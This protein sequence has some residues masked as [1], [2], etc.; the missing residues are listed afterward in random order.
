MFIR[1]D[2]AYHGQRHCE[3]ITKYVNFSLDIKFN[4]YD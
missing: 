2:S 3:C 4:L 1:V